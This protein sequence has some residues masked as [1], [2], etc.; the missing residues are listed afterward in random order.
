MATKLV[1]YLNFAGN[2]REAIT[3]YQS[4]FGGELLI[5]TFADF[6]V[7]DMPAD[8]VMHAMLTTEEFSLAA[9]DAMPGDEAK[10][11]GTRIYLA[12]MGEDLATLETWFTALAEGGEILVPLE[13]QVWDDLYGQVKDRFGLEWMFNIAAPAAS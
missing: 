11:G 1:P 7:P 2:T 4:V 3:F 6:G 12:M 10:W 5:H 9:S 8:G 13:R